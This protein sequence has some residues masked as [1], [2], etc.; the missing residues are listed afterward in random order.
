MAGKKTAAA[1]RKAPPAK[2]KKKAQAKA[3]VTTAKKSPKPPA[4]GAEKS[5]GYGKRDLEVFRKMITKQR[6]ELRAKV[7][8]M[9]QAATLASSKDASGDNSAY[10]F[11]MADLGTDAQEREMAFLFVAREGQYLEK[12]EMALRRIEEGTYGICRTCTQLIDKERLK[13]VP[14]ATQCFTCKSR[15]G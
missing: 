9:R 15:K 11:H 8:D 13:A 5:K 2:A 6:D 7:E 10:A 14:V 4:P 12:L 1:A 3:A